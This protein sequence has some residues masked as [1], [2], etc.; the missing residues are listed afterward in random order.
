MVWG[1]LLVMEPLKRKKKKEFFFLIDYL[2]IARPHSN[3]A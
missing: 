2:F 3:Q 1:K